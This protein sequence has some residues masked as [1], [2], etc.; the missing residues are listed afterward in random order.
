MP[1]LSVI[2][3]CYNEEE[4]LVESYKHTKSGV[5]TLSCESEIIYVNDGS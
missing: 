1:K 2:I 3:P 4:V 5:G